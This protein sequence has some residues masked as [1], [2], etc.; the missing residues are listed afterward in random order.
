MD[1]A[2]LPIFR[3]SM[4]RP[5]SIDSSSP[6]NA[7]ILALV[8]PSLEFSSCRNALGQGRFQDEIGKVQINARKLGPHRFLIHKRH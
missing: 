4:R 1:G 5:V 7:P 3:P 8:R 6:P 2:S